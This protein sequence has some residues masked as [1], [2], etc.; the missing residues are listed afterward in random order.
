MYNVTMQQQSGTYQTKQREVK[1]LNDVDALIAKCK[2]KAVSHEVHHA[3]RRHGLR[4]GSLSPIHKCNNRIRRHR[5]QG[6][7]T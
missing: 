6:R 7:L 1:T 3:T 4:P 5:S 2:A